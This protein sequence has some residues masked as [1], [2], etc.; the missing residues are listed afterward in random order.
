MPVSG[1]DLQMKALEPVRG[2][3]KE[4]NLLADLKIGE[5]VCQKSRGNTYLRILTD[6]T[7]HADL[8]LPCSYPF[9][10]PRLWAAP[11]GELSHAAFGSCRNGARGT[12]A[13]RRQ[14]S[15]RAAG[16]MRQGQI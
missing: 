16:G 4:Y 7:W 10:R 1:D 6:E 8:L 11:G 15:P 2:R 13:I 3:A 9:A 5:R 14:A 12:G